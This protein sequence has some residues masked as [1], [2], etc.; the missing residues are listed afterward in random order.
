MLLKKLLFKHKS[1]QGLVVR[2]TGLAAIAA[3]LAFGCWGLYFTVASLGPVFREPLAGLMLPL[4]DVKVNLALL[5]AVTVL[6]GGVLLT[7]HI[8]GRPKAADLL[9]ETESELQK[10]TWPSWPETAN[11]SIVVIFTTILLAL[12]LFLFDF[13]LRWLTGL[14]L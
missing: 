9:I 8:L 13:I 2:G 7:A 1:E 5:I 4:V 14:V 3:L 12:L 6:V 10:V 11:A